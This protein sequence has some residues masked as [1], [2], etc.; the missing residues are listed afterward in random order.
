MIRNK[1][2]ID[3]IGRKSQG[4]SSKLFKWMITNN[5]D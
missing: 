5:K 4:K 1:K 3:E 2:V